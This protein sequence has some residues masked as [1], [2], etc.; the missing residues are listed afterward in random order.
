MR[1]DF[2]KRLWIC[3]LRLNNLNSVLFLQFKTLFS[4]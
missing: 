1:F 4:G 2:Q 3:E